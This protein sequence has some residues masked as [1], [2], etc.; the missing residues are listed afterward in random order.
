MD[1]LQK[2]LDKSKQN[3]KTSFQFQTSSDLKKSFQP[4]TTSNTVGKDTVDFHTKQ[5][6]PP[7]QFDERLLLANQRDRN[8]VAAYN[9][10]SAKIIQLLKRQDD[11][12]LA[13]TSPT[14]G[15]G[16]TL[17]AANLAISI[18]RALHETVVLIELNLRAPSFYRLFGLNSNEQGLCDHLTNNQSLNDLFINIRGTEITLLPAGTAIDDVNILGSKK[19]RQL[20]RTLSSSFHNHIIVYDLPSL[21]DSEDSLAFLPNIDASLLVLEEGVS[22]PTQVTQC[23]DILKNHG[24]LGTILNK[25]VDIN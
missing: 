9:F 12:S 4:T 14:S 21:L 8:S 18:S 24:F 2:A 6:T 22:T 23:T 25:A 7:N 17:T 15:V 16:N 11:Y 3:E 1:W 20:V 5:I 10:L 19:I 13:I